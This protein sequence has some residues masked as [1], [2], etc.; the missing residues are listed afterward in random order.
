ML[1]ALQWSKVLST[2][3]QA[4]G[5]GRLHALLLSTRVA[6]YAENMQQGTGLDA[7]D[8]G[9]LGSGIMAHDWGGLSSTTTQKERK[10]EKNKEKKR[11][12]RKKRQQR[13]GKLLTLY[14]T[15]L[16]VLS[17]L[18]VCTLIQSFADCHNTNYSIP[19]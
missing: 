7:E 3:S 19:L 1:A 2:F 11:E 10:S 12:K 9:E 18:R 4:T 14:R 15:V 16:L 5:G 6:R 8:L 13:T 17:L